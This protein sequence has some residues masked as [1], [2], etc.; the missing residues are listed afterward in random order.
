LRIAILANNH[1]SMTYLIGKQS[2]A[3]LR[4][5]AEKHPDDRRS[6]VLTNK[7]ELGVAW[8]HLL[9]IG[10]ADGP[11]TLQVAVS[12]DQPEAL[13]YILE[14]YRD[15]HKDDETTRL[16]VINYGSGSNMASPIYLAAQQGSYECFDIL[17]EFGADPL[18][19]FHGWNI[20]HR[21]A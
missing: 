8:N 19:T 21:A 1:R 12:V 7:D 6:S 2:S 4:R 17:L 3:A 16:G 13:R 20:A 11:T 10:I 5:F 18:I 14:H 15:A 9:G